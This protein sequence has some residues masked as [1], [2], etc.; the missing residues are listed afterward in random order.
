MR[1]LFRRLTVNERGAALVELAIVT[2]VLLLLVM[3]II[4]FGWIFNGFITIT[5]A[6]REG[7]RVAVVD[8]DG[9]YTKAVNDHI[10]NLPRLSVSSTSKSGGAAQ[11][12]DI[13]VTVEGNIAR[14]FGGWLPVPDPFPLPPAVA[15]MR[16][17]YADD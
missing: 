2:P 12:D 16:R 5:G 7:A 13:I 3:G 9:D 15:T 6:A 11:G 8:V 4:E 10:N 14:L 1:R 17:Q